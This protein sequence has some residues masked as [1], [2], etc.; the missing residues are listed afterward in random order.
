MRWCLAL[1]ICCFLAVVNA[2]SS[3]GSRLLAILEDTEQKNL[4][5]T[6]W[7]DLEGSVLRLNP[8][9]PARG[10]DVSIES[11]KSDQ[12][13]LFKHGE[14]AYDHLLILPPKSKGGHTRFN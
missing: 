14:R 4:Y 9:S 10:Y 12:L 1:L 13:A 7:T 8:K 6:L 5:S 2:L 11:S 3:S